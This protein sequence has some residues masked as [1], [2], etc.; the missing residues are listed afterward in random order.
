[1]ISFKRIREDPT[2]FEKAYRDVVD[3][4][5]SQIPTLLSKTVDTGGQFVTTTLQTVVSRSHYELII[6]NQLAEQM[7]VIETKYTSYPNGIDMDSQL[8]SE[9]I[10][11]IQVLRAFLFEARSNVVRELQQYKANPVLRPYFR[12]HSAQSQT[13]DIQPAKS[14]SDDPIRI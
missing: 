2:E 13:D 3:Y 14:F 11:S 6:W 10:E 8:P 1:L 9:W 4:D 12:R 7:E 5:T